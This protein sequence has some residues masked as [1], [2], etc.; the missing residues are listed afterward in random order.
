MQ[1]EGRGQ[2]GASQTSGRAVWTRC[3][4]AAAYFASWAD[5]MPAISARDPQLA[6][7]A[8]RQLQGLAEAAPRHCQL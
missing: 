4:A 8:T 3:Q 5:C 7:T 6:T 2:Q 1:P